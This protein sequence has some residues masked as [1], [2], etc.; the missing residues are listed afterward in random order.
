MS[1]AVAGRPGPLL[2]VLGWIGRGT[3]RRAWLVVTIFAL[4]G[5]VA[6][7]ALR[8]SAWRRPAR[9]AF[10]QA[11]RQAAGGAFSTVLV[12][13][14]LVGLGMVAQAHYWLGMAGGRDLVG[15]VLVV[16]LVR[17]VTPL[18]IGFV[19]LGRSGTVIAVELGAMATGGQLHALRTQGL[20]AFRLLVLPRTVALAV[21]A[22]TLGILF[23]ATALVAGWLTGSLAGLVKR[24]PAEFL[25]NVLI[26]M[27]AKDFLIL[28][29][30]LVVIGALVALTAAVT[31]LF[32]DRRDD[33]ASLLP[34]GFVRG[35]LAL[36]LASGV[37]SLAA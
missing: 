5:G 34:Q 31:G 13:G 10:R 21:A 4:A 35:V 33:A 36:L 8:P 16:V 11:L 15:R 2:R 28:P 6:I 7:D 3:R 25:D 32:C 20:D 19:M 12:T 14:V 27:E 9:A 30:K 37:L 1:A 26:A 23:V 24:S 22:F 17:E 29:L 18:L